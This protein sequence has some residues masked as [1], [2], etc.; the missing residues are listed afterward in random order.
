MTVRQRNWLLIG[1]V[2]VFVIAFGLVSVPERA[3]TAYFD[4]SRPAVIAHQGGD[5]L[6]P[7]NTLLAFDHAD[8]L[9]VDVLEMDVHQ[10]R[11]G[12]LVLMH[13]ATVDRTTNGQGDITGM[14]FA[15]LRQLDAAWHWP[16]DGTAPWRGQGVTV[17]AL[18]EVLDAYPRQRFNIE[19]KQ[20]N[21][22]IGVALCALLR[23]KQVQDQALIASFHR[24]AMLDFRLACP[25]V[26]TSAHRYEVMGFVVAEGIGLPGLHRPVA[27][28]LQ[29]PLQ[30]Y[31]IELTSNAR[32][33]AAH[34]IDLYVDAWTLNDAASIE[35]AY[36]RGVD[37]VITD[38]P[39]IALAVR[40]RLRTGVSGDGGR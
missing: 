24:R 39:D 33:A 27:H 8:S 6:R 37:G 36:R 13:D 26:A 2:G 20:E 7:G 4:T 10:T 34:Q 40:S 25:E 31:G 5:G 18:H 30:Q 29:V 16:F 15:A 1:A 19:I 3:M 22:S 11:D 17:P 28:A 9:G 32:L 38:R 12:V 23:E 21:P 14:D 35:A